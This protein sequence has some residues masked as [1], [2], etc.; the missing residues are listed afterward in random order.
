MVPYPVAW[1]I[2]LLY[3]NKG[4]GSNDYDDAAG[5]PVRFN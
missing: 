5:I 3:V 1:L 2:C 4:K